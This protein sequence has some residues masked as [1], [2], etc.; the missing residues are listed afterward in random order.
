MG[1]RSKIVNNLNYT[2]IFSLID[3]STIY[4]I[5][6]AISNLLNNG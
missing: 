5:R 3:H 2:Y 4:Q 1:I 6:A